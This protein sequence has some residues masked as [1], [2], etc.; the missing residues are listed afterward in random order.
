MNVSQGLRLLF[1]CYG[2]LR[3]TLALR[4]RYNKVFLIQLHLYNWSVTIGFDSTVIQ[5]MLLSVMVML[6]F[7]F[8]IE[9]MQCFLFKET[10][11]W[12][13][14]W[15]ELVEYNLGENEE[16]VIPYLS[17]CLYGETYETSCFHIFMR[18]SRT[19]KQLWLNNLG[20][21]STI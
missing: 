7:F 18:L 17:A 3:K 20:F 14:L 12:S 5:K 21:Q 19:K 6:K 4:I 13:T 9:F 1:K 11:Y 10:F 15:A 16:L 8:K 2:F